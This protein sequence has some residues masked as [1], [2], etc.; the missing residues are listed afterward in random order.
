MANDRMY[1]R[2]NRCGSHLYLAKRMGNGWYTNREDK[3]DAPTFLEEFKHWLDLH[4]DHV[5]GG[6]H[7]GHV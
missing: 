7:R 3:P 4:D 6:T 5:W 1:L 2:C